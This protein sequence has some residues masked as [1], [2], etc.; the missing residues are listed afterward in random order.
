M[1][2]IQNTK[3]FFDKRVDDF[4]KDP[5]GLRQHVILVENQIRKVLEKDL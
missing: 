4:G 2:I 3:E 5:F 1:D